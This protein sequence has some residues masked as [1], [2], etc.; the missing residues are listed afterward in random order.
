MCT[1]SLFLYGITKYLTQSVLKS[2]VY[3]RMNSWVTKYILFSVLT[4]TGCVFKVPKK[5]VSVVTSVIKISTYS[6]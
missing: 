3:T 6:K 5:S 4:E 1:N 2:F